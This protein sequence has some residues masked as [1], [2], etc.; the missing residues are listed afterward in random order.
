MW[1]PKDPSFQVNTYRLNLR[2]SERSWL[3]T[4]VLNCLMDSVSSEVWNKIK[5]G[6]PSS[7]NSSAFSKV[8][9]LQ[10]TERIVLDRHPLVENQ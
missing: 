1:W 10:K 2:F 7:V 8:I 4:T 5:N 3:S 6:R 9:S